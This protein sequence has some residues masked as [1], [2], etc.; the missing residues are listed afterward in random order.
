MIQSKRAAPKWPGIRLFHYEVEY[1]VRECIS[2]KIAVR[3]VFSS[4]NVKSFFKKFQ[5]LS[6]QKFEKLLVQIQTPVIT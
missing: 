2:N 6:N 4:G 1:L 3:D 5:F